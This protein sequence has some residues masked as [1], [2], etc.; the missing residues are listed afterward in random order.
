MVCSCQPRLAS[1][2]GKACLQ[3]GV[4]EIN[5]HY[6]ATLA[7][8]VEH[9]PCKRT[10]VGS[11]PTGGSIYLIQFLGFSPR[12]ISALAMSSKF[13]FVPGVMPFFRNQP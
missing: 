3:D 8:L 4:G 7:Q 12:A 10:V 5:T 2:T 9:P 1:K 6:I 13:N 11:I